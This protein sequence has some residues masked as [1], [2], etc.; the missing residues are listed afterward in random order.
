MRKLLI[1]LLVAAAVGIVISKRRAPEPPAD[2]PEKKEADKTVLAEHRVEEPAGPQH[3]RADGAVPAPQAPQDG[4]GQQA[5][6]PSA[7]AAN[8]TAEP[9]T[10]PP[11]KEQAGASEPARESAARIEAAIS[12][13]EAGDRLAARKLLTDLYLAA[14]GE[15]AQKLRKLLDRINA[16]LVF[17][18]RCLEGARI[19]T[20]QPGET[21]TRIGKQYGVHWRMIARLNGMETDDLLRAGQKLKVLT[22]DPSL[23][24]WK[25]E[26]RL[27]LLLGG[28]Y[29]KEYPIGIG[30][31]DR[32]PAGQFT[33][34]DLLV[35]PR[36]YPP[37]GGII[38]YG[39]EGNLLG[40][41]WVG[42]SDEPGAAGLGIHGTNDGGI[43]TRCSNGCIRM[44]NEDVIELYAFMEVGAPVEIRE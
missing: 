14:R 4:A 40:E 8:T 17:N 38:E 19:H 39:E 9:A 13:L 23:V 5:R 24:I 29:V 36:W 2:G 7:L 31:D 1:L 28:A 22:G 37:E 21:L 33:V 27:A 20:V 43:G 16:D 12:R 44:H 11:G 41:R 3:A 18:P 26:F 15:R 25:E 35:E 30:K 6:E 10:R 42:L 34:D 32:T